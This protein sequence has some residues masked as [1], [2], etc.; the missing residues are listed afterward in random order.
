M[1]NDERFYKHKMHTLI[2]QPVRAVCC[3]H[4]RTVSAKY[5]LE[6]TQKWTELVLLFVVKTNRTEWTQFFCLTEPKRNQLRGYTEVTEPNRIRTIYNGFSRIP[7]ANSPKPL[8][9]T[10]L[11]NKKA[12]LSQRWPRDAP[13]IQSMWAERERSGKR[14]GAAGKRGERERS[15]ERVLK[16]IIW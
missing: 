3:A 15:V 5:R 12:L 16:K 9:V 10:C 14:S 8:I 2:H 1:L 13:Y 11:E 6:S 4:F 7:I